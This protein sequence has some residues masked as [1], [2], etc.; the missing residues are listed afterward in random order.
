MSTEENI[1]AFRKLI[2]VG[3]TKGDLSVV[4]ELVSPAC[5]EHQR[6][7]KPG[8]EGTKATITTLRR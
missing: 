8:S 7:N 4:D 3:F 5:I 6:G 2:D 1:A